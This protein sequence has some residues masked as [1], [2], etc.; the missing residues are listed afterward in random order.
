MACFS[1][2]SSKKVLDH[3]FNNGR[4][5]TYTPPSVLYIAL[6][7]SDAGLADNDS[8][9]WVEVSG[10]SYAREA[11]NGTTNY[12][13]EASNFEALLHADADWP[14]ATADWGTITHAAIM[15]AATGGNVLV[16]SALTTSKLIETSDIMGVLA[17]DMVVSLAS[18]GMSTYSAKK[19]LDHLL[20]NGRSLTF[21][22]PST[23][24]MA[25]FT[26]SGGLLDN[27]PASQTEV[28]GGA[29][30]RLALNGSTN[31]M[32]PA[33]AFASALYADLLWSVAT[34]SWGV[35]THAAIMDAST[36]GNVLYFGALTSSKT[37]DTNDRAV[38]KAGQVVASLT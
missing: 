14:I 4:A 19:M 6:F 24:Y 22:P 17:E 35:V 8:L 37:I 5:L 30:A 29:Y 27:T 18:S 26:T 1:S 9:S 2:Y 10:G 7:T 11:L 28:T 13:R 36:G 32:T 23:L 21:S 38:L 20:N 33:A 34:S 31:Y 12:F 3:L 16:Y 15:D 25:L